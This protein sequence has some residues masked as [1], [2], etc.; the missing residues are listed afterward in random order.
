MFPDQSFPV[1]SLLFRIWLNL[2]IHRRTQLALLMLVMLFSG[3]SELL[4]LG[5]VLPFLSVLTDP[6]KLWQQKWLQPLVLELDFT[7]AEQLVFPSTIL[8]SLAAVLAAFIRLLNLW[9]NGRLAA[10]VGS[11]LSCESYRRTLYQPYQVHVR[12]NSSTLISA[13][14]QHV[15][16]TVQ[17]INTAL[18]IIS[19]TIVSVC[20]LVGLLLVDWQVALLTA[21]LFGTAYSFIAVI[22]R[23]QLTRNGER[24]A[25]ENNN[26]IKA[27]QEGL[28]AIRDVLLDGTQNSYLDLY[29]R[30]DKPQRL[31][32]ARNIFL[33]VFPRF[34]LEALGLVAIATLGGLLVLQRGSGVGVIP[35]LGAMALGAQRLLPALQQI[36]SGWANLN[37]WSVSIE[38]VVQMLEQPLP[39]HQGRINPVLLKQ[40]I[41][42]KGVYFRYEDNSPY[43]LRNLDL[44]IL[45][46]ER[47][48]LIGATGSGKSTLVDLL[49]GLLPPNEGQLLVDGVSLHH[50]DHSASLLGWMSSVAHV[51]QTIY[52]SDSTIAENIAFGV[53]KNAIDISKVKEAAR[54]AQISEFIESGLDGYDSIVGERGICLSG[55][56]RQRIGIAR[57]L[58][59]DAN[60]II[61]DEATSA[62]DI[63]TE[64][65]VM[66][67]VEGLSRKLTIVMIAHR[68]S[69]VQRCDRLVRI[70][71]GKV[72]ESGP[73]SNVLKG[74]H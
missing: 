25:I 36:Y 51:P 45:P 70:A 72:V 47:V 2:S 69:T 29:R 74:M 37:S 22:S 15:G 35:I 49:M 42:L 64:E 13:M 44:Q 30:S 65:A 3:V 26:R 1:Y 16:L 9:L 43:V 10:A 73:P 39:K 6:E 57:A 67:A 58:Y 61:L 38:T 56:Q 52:L 71:H 12:R 41:C 55:G 66:E 24:I 17:A 21:L 68:L 59:K 33:S 62:L 54:Q 53:P 4:S 11:D 50:Q 46:G 63:A 14:T 60:V 48:G 34:A 5:A 32:E 23:R 8:F 19:A 7:Q 18:G 28:G 20:L 27:L 40:N 31:S